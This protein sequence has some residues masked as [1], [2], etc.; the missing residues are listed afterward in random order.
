ME[1]YQRSLVPAAP[2]VQRAFL[3]LVLD[4]QLALE[5]KVFRG[6]QV[7]PSL[8]QML[9]VVSA[10]ASDLPELKSLAREDEGQMG[11]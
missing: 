10:E 11:I 4:T 6:E 1:L 8:L 9:R 2:G 5:K 7:D 3:A